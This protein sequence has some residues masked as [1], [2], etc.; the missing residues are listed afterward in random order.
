MLIMLK[1]ASMQIRVLNAK[2]PNLLYSLT[3]PKNAGRYT[4]ECFKISISIDE[5]LVPPHEVVSTRV[6]FWKN[7]L[8]GFF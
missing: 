7:I 1:R 6:E 5:I 4:F 8:V 3:K 2:N